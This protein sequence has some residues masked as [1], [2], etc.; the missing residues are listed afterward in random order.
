MF[1]GLE[2][3]DYAA[4]QAE[5][6]R[7]RAAAVD[8]PSDLVLDSTIVPGPYRQRGQLIYW[9]GEQIHVL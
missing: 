6:E 5:L 9:D 2:D 8:L 7:T 3:P 1:N 4:R